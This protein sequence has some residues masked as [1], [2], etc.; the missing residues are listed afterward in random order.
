MRIAFKTELA[1]AREEIPVKNISIIGVTGYVGLELTRLLLGHP[2]VRFAHLVSSTA[3]G[4]SLADIYPQLASAKL[5]TLS[6]LNVNAICADS[7]MVF[8]ALPHGQSQQ[9]VAQLREKGA[10]V[11]DMSGDFRYDDP[12]IYAAW[13]SRHDYPELLAESVYGMPELYRDYLK[14]ADLIGNPGCYTTASILALAPLVEAGAIDLASIVVDAKSGATGAGRKPS[15]A[16]HFCEIEGDAK[17]YS[18]GTHRHTSEI[19]QE[20]G[21]LAGA[22]V[23]I[24]FT[25][26]LLPIK[27]GILATS[28][29]KLAEG[30]NS[31]SIQEIYA[32]AY[33]AEPFV[34]VYEQGNLPQLKYV[35]GSN[36]LDIG[37][38]VD[39]R[40]GRIVVVSCLDNL[41][42][43]AAG[44]AIQNFNIRFGFKETTGLDAIPWYL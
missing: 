26:H 32:E 42:K 8:T 22:D 20:L 38:V 27:R 5:P 33:H 44:Q 16:L 7:D 2:E 18:V 39:L 6:D 10:K 37:F 13:Y 24:S 40:T 15:Q 4:Q 36:Q 41:I 35:V 19:E 34:R 3:A 9:V 28:Y 30:Q 14:T 11:I 12:F 31:N 43:G 17:A 25:P 23:T 29:A 21:K 1:E